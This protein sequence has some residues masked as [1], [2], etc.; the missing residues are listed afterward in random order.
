LRCQGCVALMMDNDQ[1]VIIDPYEK[2]SR[3]NVQ[4]GKQRIVSM[5]LG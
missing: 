5:L 4:L 2:T 1:P 3:A